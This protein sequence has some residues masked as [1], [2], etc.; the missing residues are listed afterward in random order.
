MFIEYVQSTIFILF[1]C[2]E[3]HKNCMIFSLGCIVVFETTPLL[4]VLVATVGSNWYL[5]VCLLLFVL[6]VI[7]YIEMEDV[8]ALFLLRM[9]G[10]LESWSFKFQLKALCY[11]SRTIMLNLLALLIWC[12]WSVGT[13]WFLTENHFGENFHPVW[14]KDSIQNLYV[15]FGG[16]CQGIAPIAGIED[17]IVSNF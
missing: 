16:S 11:L 9:V 8:F 3:I 17:I 15:Q 10:S 12:F 4:H 13:F 14:T 5:V 2:V 7:Y 6:K 1:P